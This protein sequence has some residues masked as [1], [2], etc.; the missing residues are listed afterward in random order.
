MDNDYKK[1]G[2]LLPE[3][4]KDLIDVLKPRRP[5]VA[6]FPCVPLPPVIG[7]MM[8]AEH[9]TVREL[10]RA[11]KQKLF[12]IVADLIELQIMAN[13]DQ[14]IPFDVIAQVARKHGYVAR[15]AT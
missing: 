12:Q 10:A 9:M 6:Q 15:R 4:C 8:L 11:L 7:E 1:R 2:Y 3:G 14:A 13:V 5:F